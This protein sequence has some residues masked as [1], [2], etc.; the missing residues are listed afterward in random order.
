MNKLINISISQFLKFT[1][2]FCSIRR[3]LKGCT[4]YILF[5]KSMPCFRVQ[6]NKIIEMGL[7]FRV[8]TK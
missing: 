8:H 2:V 3:Q 5:R 1:F 6:D 7:E 4:T